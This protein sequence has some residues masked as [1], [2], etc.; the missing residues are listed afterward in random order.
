MTTPFNP[1]AD[2]FDVFSAALSQHCE[3]TVATILQ[4][5]LAPG[6][7]ITVFVNPTTGVCTIGALSAGAGGDGSIVPYGVAA[8][9]AT[10]IT[11]TTSPYLTGLVAGQE[12]A[13]KLSAAITGATKI[14][15]DNLGLF[16]LTDR[17]AGALV[18]GA[19]AMGD[20]LEAI[21]DGARFRVTSTGSGEA[22]PTGG[23]TLPSSANRFPIGAYWAQAVS[24]LGDDGVAV[25]RPIALRRDP[26]TFYFTY[27]A[28][29]NGVSGALQFSD[30]PFTK[31]QTDAMH[32]AFPSIFPTVPVNGTW[33]AVGGEWGTYPGGAT[34]PYPA[35]LFCRIA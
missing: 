23:Y 9:T 34:A 17:S 24:V 22:S 4:H 25:G 28:I 12:I 27:A 33:I 14:N 1:A 32:A 3:V 8:G 11:V 13:V 16:D 5:A 19:Y 6:A 30:E 20:V 31:S 10:E 15:V 21:W 18:N 26:V 2:H 7:G 29:Y 35:G